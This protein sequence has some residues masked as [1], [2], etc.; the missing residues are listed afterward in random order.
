MDCGIDR[1]RVYEALRHITLKIASLQVH[2]L[3]LQQLKDLN[4][5]IDPIALGDTSP[6]KPT[7]FAAY[8]DHFL[9]EPTDDAIGD[10]TT[11]WMVKR[12]I[13]SPALSIVRM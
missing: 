11:A 8:L 13:L 2:D 9:P 6:Q 3:D 4:I 5:H 1:P 7:Y 12:R 10:H